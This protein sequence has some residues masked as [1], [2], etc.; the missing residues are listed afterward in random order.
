M[1][2]SGTRL[3]RGL[4]PPGQVLASTLLHV[5]SAQVVLGEW[6]SP[7]ILEDEPPLLPYGQSDRVQGVFPQVALTNR[8]WTSLGPH[9]TS[10]SAHSVSLLL[11]Q[12]KASLACSSACSF[13]TDR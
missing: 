9:D 13:S 6:D 8:G 12:A 2:V 11:F 4:R 10:S 3:E 1:T 7:K 5:H